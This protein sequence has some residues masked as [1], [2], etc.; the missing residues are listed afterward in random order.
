MHDQGIPAG[1]SVHQ[2]LAPS[3]ASE[4]TNETFMKVWKIDMLVALASKARGSGIFL[5][6]LV[7]PSRRRLLARA[8]AVWTLPSGAAVACAAGRR[9]R[10]QPGD[11]LFLGAR[12]EMTDTSQMFLELAG[13]MLVAAATSP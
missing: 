8:V 2:R 4:R 1:R 3:E 5:S 10:R 7:V 12:E 9:S 11:R 6:L 13:F